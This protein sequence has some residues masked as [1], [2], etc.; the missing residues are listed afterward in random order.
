[1]YT[2]VLLIFTLARPKAS[3]IIVTLPLQETIAA[4]EEKRKKER[5][6]YLK[7]RDQRDKDRGRRSR[8]ITK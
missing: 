6:D 1:M 4:K 5:E 7:E 8:Y 2:Q 3:L